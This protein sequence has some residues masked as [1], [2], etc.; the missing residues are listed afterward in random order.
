MLFLKTWQN[1]KALRIKLKQKPK[2]KLKV[3]N[4]LLAKLD[5]EPIHTFFTSSMNSSLEIS[6]PRSILRVIP[7][8]TGF[9]P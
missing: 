2:G 7:V 9:S 6:A 4:K 8:L 3:N 5:Y 1:L